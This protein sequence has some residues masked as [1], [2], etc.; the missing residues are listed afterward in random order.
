MPTAM[1]REKA[2]LMRFQMLIRTLLEIGLEA[3][4][5][6]SGQR[7]CL[8]FVHVLRIRVGL[9]LSVMN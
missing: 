4:H 6:S 8:H 5:I 9:N 1:Q 2:R 7:I 3:M